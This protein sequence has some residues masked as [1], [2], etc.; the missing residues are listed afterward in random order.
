MYCSMADGW[1]T[2]VPLSRHNRRPAACLIGAPLRQ[3]QLAECDNCDKGAAWACEVC[4]PSLTDQSACGCARAVRRGEHSSAACKLRVACVAACRSLKQLLDDGDSHSTPH[5]VLQNEIACGCMNRTQRPGDR[6]QSSYPQ[7]CRSSSMNTRLTFHPICIT[8]HS[9][10][11]NHLCRLFD[12]SY[13][14]LTSQVQC[15]RGCMPILY[16]Q[17]PLFMEC[18]VM[19]EGYKTDVFETDIQCTNIQYPK[20]SA[21]RYAIL[22][23]HMCPATQSA[24]ERC[25]CVIRKKLCQK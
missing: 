4:C 12:V 1:C 8:S 6:Q 2:Y 7:A 3:H 15:G 25:N 23:G 9:E 16:G 10:C 20:H 21:T 22:H 5:V 17:Q 18:C 24:T 14:S 11:M 19:I 13:C